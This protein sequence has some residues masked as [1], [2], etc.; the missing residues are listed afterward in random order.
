MIGFFGKFLLSNLLRVELTDLFK[1]MA[2]LNLL[3]K[4][5]IFFL[6]FVYELYSLS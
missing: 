6:D 2:L 4:L 3:L 5:L 1:N